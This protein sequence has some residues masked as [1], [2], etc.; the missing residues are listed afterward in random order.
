MKKPKDRECDWEQERCRYWSNSSVNFDSGMFAVP[1]CQATHV[2]RIWF[3]RSW[4]CFRTGQRPTHLPQ[5]QKPG[6]EPSDPPI[7]NGAT[8]SPHL[9]MLR[10]GQPWHGVHHHSLSEGSGW[11]R[12]VWSVSGDLSPQKDPDTFDCDQDWT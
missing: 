12:V 6:L 2:L 3:G 5:C 7:S 4:I 1:Q 8:C 11:W 9:A 10:A